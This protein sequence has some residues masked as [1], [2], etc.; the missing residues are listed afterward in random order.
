MVVTGH[1][2]GIIIIV[3]GIIIVVVTII[4]VSII[5]VVGGIIIVV[6][7]MRTKDDRLLLSCRVYQLQVM[8]KNHLRWLK[9]RGA[10]ST[11]NYK[12]QQLLDYGFI[13]VVKP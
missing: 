7:M 4:V 10:I 9:H 11:N 8:V 6:T 3:V 5:I 2:V 13:I 12:C 1:L